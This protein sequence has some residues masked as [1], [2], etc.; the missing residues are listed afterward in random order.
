M[1]A[2]FTLDDA[3][4]VLDWLRDND[5][6][7]DAGH[8]L[9]LRRILDIN[10]RSRA[11]LNGSPATLQQVREVAEALVDIHG[12]H[13]H[14]SLLRAE[15]SVRCSM[16]HARLT[17]SVAAVAAAWRHWRE[18]VA[19]Q[20]SARTGAGRGPKAPNN[21]FGR[22]V[23]WK[24]WVFLL[25]GGGIS[26]L[27]TRAL[28]M[29]PVW[30][31]APAF[32]WPRCPRTMSLAK[33]GSTQPCR[34]WMTLSEFDPAL[35]GI[36][37]LLQAA[38]AELGEAVSALHRY[39]DRLELDPDRLNEIERRLDAVL[40]CARKYRVTPDELSDLL[41]RWRQH[42]AVLDETAD[43]AALEHARARRGSA[44]NCWQSRFRQHAPR[45]PGSWVPRSAG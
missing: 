40:G 8:G 7:G 33:R 20:E 15:L 45:R 43:L 22:Y 30:S 18:A 14:Q 3:P 31:T 37:E 38:R 39:A 29:P 17:D 9:L 42:L 10:G 21:S 4:T 11:Y 35:A 25:R 27:N 16:R 26:T 1:S 19:L 34:G 2:E 5:L 28:R 13:A 12:Q 6:D 32:R 36:T 44:M 24:P 41:A 23:N